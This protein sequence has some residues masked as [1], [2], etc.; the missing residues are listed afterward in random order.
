MKHSI[1]SIFFATFFAFLP[2]AFAGDFFDS[3]QDRLQ[4]IVEAHE[5]PVTYS[6]EGY[7]N[8]RCQVVDR[9]YKIDA[10]FKANCVDKYGVNPNSIKEMIWDANFSREKDVFAM[11]NVFEIT[12][13]QPYVP[14]CKN[15]IFE[16]DK[17]CYAPAPGVSGF[18][19]RTGTPCVCEDN[20]NDDD[21]WG[22][23]PV[24]EVSCQFD[25]APSSIVESENI[26]M[27]RDIILYRAG[28]EEADACDFSQDEIFGWNES[29]KKTCKLFE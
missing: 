6:A 11:V 2:Q 18:L 19:D 12:N 21:Q 1:P 26:R 17:L 16:A 24:N 13:A 14:E 5:R 20:G 10:K 8:C 23:D 4:D 22:W 25:F 29:A 9:R 3:V 27:E 15:A 7:P 28:S